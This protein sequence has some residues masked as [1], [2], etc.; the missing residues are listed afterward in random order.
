MMTWFTWWIKLTKFKI[1]GSVR[2]FLQKL[3]IGSS[4][5]SSFPKILKKCEACVF[6]IK[7]DKNI[8]HVVNVSHGVIK[9]GGPNG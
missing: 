4:Y 7:D 2:L 8:S 9:I 6:L 5:E 1:S 3:K